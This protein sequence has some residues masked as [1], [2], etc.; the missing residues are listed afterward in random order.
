M[1]PMHRWTS[2]IHVH[3][4]STNCTQWRR[5]HLKPERREPGERSGSGRGGESATDMVEVSGRRL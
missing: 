1:F 4:G 2:H 3:V 5:G